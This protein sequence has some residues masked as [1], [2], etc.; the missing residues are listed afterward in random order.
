MIKATLGFKKVKIDVDNFSLKGMIE[1]TFY[2]FGAENVR[3]LHSVIKPGESFL[4]GVSNMVMDNDVPI[5]FEGTN[6]Q[7]RNLMCYFGSPVQDC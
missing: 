3:V 2:N 5:Y 6:K 4:A 1:P 7:G